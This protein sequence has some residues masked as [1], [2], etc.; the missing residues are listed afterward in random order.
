MDKYTKAVLTVIALL[1]PL[2][3]NAQRYFCEMTEFVIINTDGTNKYENQKFI[4]N[5]RP[6]TVSFFS[7]GY[8]RNSRSVIDYWRGH[9]EWSAS[10]KNELKYVDSVYRF[11]DGVLNASVVFVTQITS[12]RARC[13]PDERI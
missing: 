11:G 7:D 13:Q 8:F 9:D 5:V 6:N 10:T 12:I 4:M 2:T 3:A 1:L